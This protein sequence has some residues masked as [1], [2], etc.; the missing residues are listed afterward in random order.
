M[1]T[2]KL[3]QDLMDEGFDEDSIRA[4]YLIPVIDTAWADG[5]IQPEEK[6]EILRLLEDREIRPGSQAY[7]LIESWLGRKPVD[8]FFVHANSFLE[9]L[10]RDLKLNRR[11]NPYWVVDAAER[12][13]RATGH[14]KEPVSPGEKKVIRSIISRLNFGEPRIR[15]AE[16]SRI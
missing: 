11:G 15:L 10:F 7:A 9:P 12:V 8:G 14:P 13:A 16:G 1:K 3:M 2:D 5:K 6:R 4:L